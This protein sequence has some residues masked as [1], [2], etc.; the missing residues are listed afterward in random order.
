MQRQIQDPIKHQHMEILAKIL[1][2]INPVNT[3]A[4]HSQHQEFDRV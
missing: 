3:S 2:G 1:N 4:K